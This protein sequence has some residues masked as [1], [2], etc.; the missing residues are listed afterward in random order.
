MFYHVLLLCSSSNTFPRCYACY[1]SPLKGV[2]VSGVMEIVVPYT[3]GYRDN[4]VAVVAC[5]G[6]ARKLV[7]AWPTLLLCYYLKQPSNQP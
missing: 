2:M 1:T 5:S 4:M 7:I 6:S 3:C